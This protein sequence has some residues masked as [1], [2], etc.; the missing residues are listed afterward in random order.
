MQL[1][2]MTTESPSTRAET[3]ADV[4]A[5]PGGTAHEYYALLERC[6]AGVA[7]LES[8]GA[9]RRMN[10]MCLRLLGLS[11]RTSIA[12]EPIGELRDLCHSSGIPQEREI[13]GPG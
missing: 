5:S 1:S 9:I 4:S 7:I 10:A 12:P 11:N 6:G 2:L 3:T 13:R 8:D